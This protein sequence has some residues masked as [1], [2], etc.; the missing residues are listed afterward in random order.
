MDSSRQKGPVAGSC[1][2]GNEP[3]Y[4]IQGMEFLEYLSDN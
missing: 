4:S 2:H 1:E 3:S